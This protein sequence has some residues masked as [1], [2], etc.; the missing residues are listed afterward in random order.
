M[1]AKVDLHSVTTTAWNA[2]LSPNEWASDVI[3]WNKVAMQSCRVLSSSICGI[4]SSIIYIWTILSC[5]ISLNYSADLLLNQISIGPSPSPLLISYLQ[6]GMITRLVHPLDFFTR[7]PSVV[8][9]SRPVQLNSY[10]FF[11]LS[12]L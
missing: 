5:Y 6:Y 2:R 12:F 8:S 3:E 11:S 10:P 4:Y 1:T 7:L 9:P